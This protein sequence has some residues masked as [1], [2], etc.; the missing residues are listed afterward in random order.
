MALK[1]RIRI[2]LALSSVVL[3]A[4]AV[5]ADREPGFRSTEKAFYA[6]SEQL[7]FVRPGLVMSITT[8]SIA[9]D[10]TI[11]ARVKFTDPKGVPLDRSGT[12]TPGPITVSFLI[13]YIPTDGGQYISYITRTR[14]GAAG[15]VTQ[16]TGESN[17]QWK[18]NAIGD[19]T[20]TF[21]NK[22]PANINR[23]LTHTV[24]MYGSRNLTEFDL[25]V[26]R[27]DTV[28]NFLP[29]GGAVTNV[30]DLIRT[31]SCNKCHDQLA[32]HGGNR[33]SVEVCNICHTQQTP[34]STTGNTTDMKVMIHKI[35]MG[36]SLPSVI[37]GG[38][39]GIANRDYSTVVN[40]SPNMACAVCHEPKSVSGATQADQWMARPSALTCGSCH[41]NVN[42][43][44]GENHSGGA[45]ADDK[46]C[47]NCH[48]P[49]GDD[50]GA[51][52]GGAHVVP[53]DSS[54]L[55]GV[56]FTI[57]SVTNVGPGMKPLLAF[58]L[59]DKA[60]NPWGL[61]QMNSLR[62]YM[63]G[64]TTD[65]PSYVRETPTATTAE[66]SNGIYWY[67]FTAA[68]PATAKGSWQFGMEGYRNVTLFEGTPDARTI[69]DVGPNKIVA[70]SLDGSKAQPRRTVVTTDKCNRCHYSLSFHGGNRNQAD[71]CTFCHNPN[72]VEGTE[73]ESW[74]YVNMIHRSHSEVVRYP[75]NLYNCSQCHV[76]DSQSL[77]L[78]A[79]LLPVAN[80]MAPVDPTPVMTN[81]CLSCH[82]EDA[83]WQ[84]A[85]SST[86][87]LGESCVVCHS[88]TSE[89]SVA[90]V[91]A[92]Q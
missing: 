8:A 37:A 30:R 67:S 54:L 34:D 45:Q 77:P 42:F 58:T 21:A 27:A 9:A 63:A 55:P 15:T 10:G 85:L 19:Y 51:S 52:I 88:R 46:S 29:A 35:H 89:F 39:Y 22:A 81:A 3:I 24:G 33:R 18:E 65:I 36:A 80:G 92:V 25:G 47:A 14:T 82:N 60:G 72:L 61:A 84:H 13:G 31:S 69:R 1:S 28:F 90:K 91:H 26:N 20:Y 7:N 74:N 53:A 57:E 78:Q 16:A 66:G 68:I 64:P 76:N 17:G 40:P 71:M 79:G 49:T 43:A 12:Q 70:A 50:F 83:P 87:K 6:G 23:G 56:R 41:D 44:T 73:R 2:L 59:R 86:T 48:K 75:G 38:K 5:S 11:T 62:L 4:A 32:F